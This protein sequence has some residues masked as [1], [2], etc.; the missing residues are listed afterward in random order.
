MAN[1]CDYCHKPLSLMRRLRGEQFCSLEH[2]D[3]YSAQQAEFALERLAASVIEKP[4]TDRPPSPRPKLRPKLV[5]SGGPSQS[6]PSE[7][8]AQTA[9]A[10][11]EPEARTTEKTTLLAPDVDYPMAAYVAQ[12]PVEPR[13]LESDGIRNGAGFAPVDHWGK[14]SPA[15]SMPAFHSEP[16]DPRTWNAGKLVS[17]I[18]PVAGWRWLQRQGSR[19]QPERSVSLSWSWRTFFQLEFKNSF[20]Y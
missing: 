17:Q 19:R 2:M 15:W 14:V 4:N 10:L 12:V 8:S 3:L 9:V 16:G 6:I 1:N 20:D 13:T 5:N 11:H 18:P 7:P